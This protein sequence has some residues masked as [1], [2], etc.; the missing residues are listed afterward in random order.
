M[1][2]SY[3]WTLPTRVFHWLFALLILVAFLTDDDKL[4]QYHAVVGY[5]IL[6]LITFRLIWGFAGPKYSKFKDFPFGIQKVKAFIGNI[7]NKEQNEVGHNPPASYVMMGMLILAVLIIVTGALAFGVQEGKGIFSFLNDSIFKKMKL[8]KEIHELLANLFIVLI[9]A[10]LGG[11]L[12]DKILHSKHETLN[13]IVTGYKKTSVQEGITL[14]FFQK[15]IALFFLILLIAFL[16]F[17]IAEPKNVLVASKYTP[18]DYTAQ[19]ELFVQECASCHT[20]YPS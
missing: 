19:N 12:V 15:L 11:I 10:H 13:S 14:T 5:A 9:V 8:F 16:I 2:K 7:F 4:L 20:L 17:N 1:F 6:I 18:I 3:I